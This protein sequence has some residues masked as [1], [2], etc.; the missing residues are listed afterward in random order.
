MYCIIAF[1][2]FLDHGNSQRLHSEAPFG[3]STLS[4]RA[5]GTA[6]FKGV[7]SGADNAKGLID[8]AVVEEVRS[9]SISFLQTQIVHLSKTLT[10]VYLRHFNSLSLLFCSCD[11]EPSSTR[12]IKSQISIDIRPFSAI[13]SAREA[14]GTTRSSRDGKVRLGIIVGPDG[15]DDDSCT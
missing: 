3:C 9:T 15:C 2:I 6:L 13:K 11:A 8:D 12:S 5:S 14:C 7:D 4:L 10:Q 1:L